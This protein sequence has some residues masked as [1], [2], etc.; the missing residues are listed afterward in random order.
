MSGSV[1]YAILVALGLLSESVFA[2][3]RRSRRRDDERRRPDRQRTPCNLVEIDV[4]SY[5]FHDEV[6]KR[7]NPDVVFQGRAPVWAAQVEPPRFLFAIGEAYRDVELLVDAPDEPGP[8]GVFNVNVRQG[9][10]ASGGVTITITR[11]G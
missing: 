5:E 2:W 11:G 8:P 10:V 6:G 4:D 7:F 1:G 3:L 9:G